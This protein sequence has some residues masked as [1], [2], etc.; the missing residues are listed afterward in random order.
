[1]LQGRHPIKGGGVETT[2]KRVTT[3]IQ[4]LQRRHGNLANLRNGVLRQIQDLKGRHLLE[5][6][7]QFREF[8]TRQVQG[9]QRLECRDP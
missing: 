1:M 3:Q 5:H 7:G 4:T 6:I 8:I 9:T 2:C